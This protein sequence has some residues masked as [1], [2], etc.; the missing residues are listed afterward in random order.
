MFNLS[1]ERL[2]KVLR[3]SFAG[4]FTTEDMDSIDPALIRFLG[5]EGGLADAA[6]TA[7]RAWSRSSSH[8]I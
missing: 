7:D 3:L 1:F 6:V 2:R 8:L 4:I 5:G